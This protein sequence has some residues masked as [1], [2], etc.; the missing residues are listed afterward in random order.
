MKIASVLILFLLAGAFSPVR[1]QSPV[2]AVVTLPQTSEAGKS[3]TAHVILKKGD[4]S[5]IGRFQQTWPAGFF[6]SE[7]ENADAI[8]SYS[9]NQLQFLWVDLPI[10]SEINLSYTVQVPSDYQGTTDITNQF[11]YLLNNRQEEVLFP[12]NPLTITPDSETAPQVATPPVPQ[13]TVPVEA[14]SESVYFSIQLSAFSKPVDKTTIAKEFNL[15]PEVVREEQHNGLIKYITGRY[16]SVQE[17]KKAVAENKAMTGNV[18]ITG[19]KD[20]VRIELEE[21]IHL[22]TK[23]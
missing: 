12:S 5:G 6:I 20:N 7:L 9:G 21:A 14:A 17:A 3:F 8:F 16:K 10:A 15:K 13:K 23:H 18:F 11:Y 2:S 19:Y 22:S 4:A 1:S